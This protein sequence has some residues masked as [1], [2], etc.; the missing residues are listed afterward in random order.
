MMPACPILG[1]GL[2]AQLVAR[3]VQTCGLILHLSLVAAMS[4]SAPGSPARLRWVGS[5]AMRAART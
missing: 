3:E 5:G 4:N 2:F 1:R